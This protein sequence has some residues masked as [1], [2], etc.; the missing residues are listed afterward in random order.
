MGKSN[1]FTY[2]NRIMYEEIYIWDNAG[3]IHR[4]YSFNKTNDGVL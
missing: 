3:K 1:R 2:E 4:S